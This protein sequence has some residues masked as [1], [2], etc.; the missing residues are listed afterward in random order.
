MELKVE[1]KKSDSS[2]AGYI[3]WERL[4]KHL[5]TSGELNDNEIIVRIEADRNGINYYVEKEK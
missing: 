1:L 5:K 2:T 3:S 4:A